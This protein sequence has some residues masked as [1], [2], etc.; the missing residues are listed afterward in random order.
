MT[1][2][3]KAGVL[4]ADCLNLRSETHRRMRDIDTQ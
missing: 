1:Q 3:T 2:G 4:L